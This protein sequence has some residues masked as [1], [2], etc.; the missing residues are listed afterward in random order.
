M[1]FAFIYENR[2]RKPAEIVLIRGR[3]G[4]RM[5]EE[6]NLKYI[7]STFVNTIMYPQYSYYMVIKIF[8]KRKKIR[9]IFNC[10]FIDLAIYAFPFFFSLE[11]AKN[12]NVC[13]YHYIPM[14]LKVVFIL[15][16]SPFFLLF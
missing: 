5:M 12:L 15:F 8:R 16:F 11:F 10:H 3:G 14:I 4:G 2:R 6:I 9:E 7:V 13:L 1:Y